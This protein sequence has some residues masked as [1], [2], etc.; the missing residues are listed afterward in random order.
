MVFK[1]FAQTIRFEWRSYQNRWEKSCK[2][3]ELESGPKQ[4]PPP[5]R[6]SLT[7]KVFLLTTVFDPWGHDCAA[8]APFVREASVSNARA[9]A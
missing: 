5:D 2:A 8:P 3:S 7:A 6:P 9:P 1:L 4:Q